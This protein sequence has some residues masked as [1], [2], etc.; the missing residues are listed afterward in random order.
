MHAFAYGFVDVSGS[1]RNDVL[2]VAVIAATCTRRG[3]VRE[4]IVA[5][6]VKA[7]S[8][9]FFMTNAALHVYKL[10]I[11]L[12]DQ[13]RNCWAKEKKCHSNC[14]QDDVFHV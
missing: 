6:K 12:E 13:F 10:L 8:R 14:P 1:G 3:V 7:V 11:G 4:G 2:L 5:S 9:N